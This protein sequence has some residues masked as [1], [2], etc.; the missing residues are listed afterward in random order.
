MWSRSHCSHRMSKIDSRLPS[1]KTYK[2]LS[3]LPWHAMSILIQLHTGPISL[4]L[5]LKKIKAVDSA[6]CAC[7]QQPETVV[8]FLKYCKYF[9]GQCNQLRHEVGKASH[10]TLHLLGVSKTIPSTLHYI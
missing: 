10:S 4:N 7:C 1:Y 2:M 3:S 5:F 8:H 9:A 6:L